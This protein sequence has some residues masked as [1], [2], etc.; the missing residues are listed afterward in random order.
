MNIWKPTADDLQPSIDAAKASGDW[1]TAYLAGIKTLI[2]KNPL[3]YRA[4]GPY[5]WLVKKALIDRGETAFGDEID[6]E[7]FDA[8]DYGNKEQNIA[9]AYAYENERTEG[10]LNVYDESH[11]LET[12][13]GEPYE[14]VTGDSEVDAMAQV[15]R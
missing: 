2:Q 9:A 13:D 7:W 3:R 12:G 6:R 4:F 5:W 1:V 8:L 14:Y 15:A 10:N 11:M